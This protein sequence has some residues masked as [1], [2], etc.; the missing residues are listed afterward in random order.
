MSGLGP[1]VGAWVRAHEACFEVS[2]L[3]ESVKERKLQVGFTISLYARLPLEKGPGE[4]RQAA[5]TE[6]WQGLREILQSL[7]PKEGSNAR[8]E[9]EAP[10]TAA[11]L[12]PE[13]QMKP[14]IGLNARVFHAEEYF[15]E[16]TADERAGL[17]AVT[18]RLTDMGLRQ[19]HW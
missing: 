18:K 2:P 11:L 7:V 14:E 9:I 15:A 13:N 10:R 19:G 4:D 17:S 3:V 12:R 16:V 8:V 1:D 5:A 6:I